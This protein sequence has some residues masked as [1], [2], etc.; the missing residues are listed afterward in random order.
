M[1][2][3]I[4]LNEDDIKSAIE[5]YVRLQTGNNVTDVNITST[6]ENLESTDPRE[7]SGRYVSA[8]VVLGNK[9][10]QPKD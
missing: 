1:Q 8:T 7:R 10:A 3:K 2:H 9:A 5:Y 6:A 4:E